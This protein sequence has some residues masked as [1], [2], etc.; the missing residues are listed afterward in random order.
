MNWYKK[1]QDSFQRGDKVSVVQTNKPPAIRTD[2]D[3]DYYY[4]DEDK[5]YYWLSK[6]PPSYGQDRGSSYKFD[7][8]YNI[9]EKI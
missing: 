7:K 5:D 8:F 1:A 3:K 9:V 2:I 4:I 6:Y